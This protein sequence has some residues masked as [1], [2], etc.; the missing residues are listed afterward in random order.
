MRK[1]Y[2]LRPEYEGTLVG[3]SVI[4]GTDAGVMDIKQALEEHDGE[5][6]TDDAVLQSILENYY[7]SEGLMFD[8][9]QVTEDDERVPLA[10]PL[11][12]PGPPHS[13]P[14]GAPI[15]QGTTAAEELI[16][17]HGNESPYATFTV[18]EL[19]DTM[20]DRGLEFKAKA[21]K[22]ELVAS[23]EADDLAGVNQHAQQ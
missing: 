2:K 14:A 5:I 17:Q 10:S 9:A 15:Q 12:N 22:D 16:A 23:L 1:A 4:T 20:N 8:V 11:E 21:T 3:G 19:K 13:Q 7:G 6:V 18:D